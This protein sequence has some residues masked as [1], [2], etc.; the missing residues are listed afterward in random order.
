MKYTT[1]HCV[2]YNLISHCSP[3]FSLPVR[4]GKIKLARKRF[5]AREWPRPA[6][7]VAVPCSM[8]LGDPSTLGSHFAPMLV[9]ASIRAARV[10]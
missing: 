3:H 8:E 9:V 2:V 10:R 4:T 5:T 6:K 1:D 7:P